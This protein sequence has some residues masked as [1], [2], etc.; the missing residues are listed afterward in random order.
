MQVVVLAGG[1]G[2]RLRGAIPEG[3]PKPMAPVAGRPFL[4]HLLD[5]SIEAGADRILLL[6][7]HAAQVIVDHFGDAYR[8]VP[9][10]YSVEPS[11][12]G[13]GGA[14]RYAAADLAEEFVL[15]NGDTYTEVD[16]AAL[17]ARPGPLALSLTAVEDTGRFGRVRVEGDAVV[18]LLEKGRSGPGYINAGVYGCRRSLLD[19]FPDA[20]RFS[21]ETDVMEPS[22]E[23]L[24]PAYQLTGEV[25]FDIG[26]PDD[27]AAAD[28]YFSTGGAGR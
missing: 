16:L 10:G 17:L 28:A 1:L 5:R 11:P 24:R 21:F 27:Y 20:E 15:L 4:E 3:T 18:E 9:I 26:V 2:T 19:L 14:L 12:L 6:V 23:R 13:T 22:V 7:S 25:F 8:G